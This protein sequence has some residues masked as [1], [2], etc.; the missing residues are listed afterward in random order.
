MDA[1]LHTVPSETFIARLQKDV[2]HRFL[3]FRRAIR[4]AARKIRDQCISVAK[5]R[6]TR[7]F[8]CL[9]SRRKVFVD[10]TRH[11]QHII[12]SNAAFHKDGIFSEQVVCDVKWESKKHADA[13]A[14]AA[15][16]DKRKMQVEPRAASVMAERLSEIFL[17]RHDAPCGCLVANTQNT[18]CRVNAEALRL[19]PCAFELAL[20]AVVHKTQWKLQVVSKIADAIANKFRH[21]QCVAFA[22]RIHDIFDASRVETFHAT[23]ET[24]QW[25]RRRPRIIILYGMGRLLAKQPKSRKQHANCQ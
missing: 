9:I 2:A 16:P 14:S 8:I 18:N 1:A 20:Q 13:I 25:I 5:I 15:W 23:V 22:N 24:L 19:I 17:H 21:N 10:H 11:V 6:R 12:A 3:V 4:R 7:Q